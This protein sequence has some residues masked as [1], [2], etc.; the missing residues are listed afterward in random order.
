M[1]LQQTA[2]PLAFA[3]KVQAGWKRI[4]IIGCFMQLCATL[5]QRI[6]K[7][8]TKIK[9]LIIPLKIMPKST[10]RAQCNM[11]L[12]AVRSWSNSV[13]QSFVFSSVACKNA[14]LL[15]FG[16]VE[17]RKFC[18]RSLEIFDFPTIEPQLC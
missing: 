17:L 9:I 2:C 5:M 3:D 13:G 12:E 10:P 11:S 14:R 1:H 18:I 6:H 4:K 15:S 8:S 16:V 7:T